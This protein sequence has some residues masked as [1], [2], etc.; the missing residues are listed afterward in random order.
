MNKI[1]AYLDILGFG[2]HIYTNVEEA[3]ELLSDYQTIINQKIIDNKLHPPSSYPSDLQ[4]LAKQNIVDSFEYFL[5]FS[6]SLFIQSSTPNDFLKQISSFLLDC[7]L[8]K[9]NNYSNPEDPSDP[10]KVTIKEIGIEEGK[11]IKKEKLSHWH[12]LL[13]RGGISYGETYVFDINAIVDSNLTQINN[14]AGPALVKAV[15]ELEPLG[16]G[17]RLFCDIDFYNKLDMSTKTYCK[18]LSD[19]HFEILWPAFYFI[20]GNDVTSE[21]YKIYELIRPVV[22]LWKAY[23]HLSFGAHYFE[24]L[25]LVISASI[26][27]FDMQGN[28]KIAEDAISDCLKSV[29]LENKEYALKNKA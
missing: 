6:D 8:L 16:K 13:F 2:N 25:R 28:K 12:P 22:N 15:K 17:P 11:V 10:S 4:K 20:K 27:F 19:E 7:F 9:S 1:V 14:I 3:L 29:G 18:K 21:I 23:N 5:P 24:F 26:M